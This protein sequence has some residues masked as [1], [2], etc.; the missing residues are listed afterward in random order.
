MSL[1]P[2]PFKRPIVGLRVWGTLLIF[3][4]LSIPIAGCLKLPQPEHGRSIVSRIIDGDTIELN[5]GE[6][7][8]LL[9]IDTPET[10]HSS[11]TVQ[12]LGE[13]S[14]AHLSKLALGKEVTIEQQHGRHDPYGRMLA[15]VYLE[16]GGLLN[17]MMVEDGFALPY[18]KYPLAKTQDFILASQ[19]ARKNNRGLWSSSEFTQDSRLARIRLSRAGVCH[20][21]GNKGYE[22][23]TNFKEFETMKDCLRHG[24]KRVKLARKSEGKN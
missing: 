21:P 24:G 10:R 20:S 1:L 4:S 18:T 15:Y 17:L 16:D 3:L 2:L 5:S 13:R 6:K 11:S 8:R 12:K 19:E 9:G 14:K 22:R 23:L 7:I